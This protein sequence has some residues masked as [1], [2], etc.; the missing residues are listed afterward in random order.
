MTGDGEQPKGSQ[1]P[2]LLSVNGKAGRTSGRSRPAR[3]Q[4]PIRVTMSSK[5]NSLMTALKHR[6]LLPALRLRRLARI[7]KAIL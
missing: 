6:V 3:Y 2:G 1:N 4:N 5:K 7:T